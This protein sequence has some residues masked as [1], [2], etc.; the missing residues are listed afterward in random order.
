MSLVA[1]PT[2]LRV[3]RMDERVRYRAMPRFELEV[4]GTA[5]AGETFAAICDRLA[6]AVGEADAAVQAAALV[7]AWLSEGLLARLL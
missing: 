3:W 6:S 4:L 5:R 2:C 7:S 1:E